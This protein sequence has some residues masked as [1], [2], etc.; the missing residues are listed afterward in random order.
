MFGAWAAHSVSIRGSVPLVTRRSRRCVRGVLQHRPLPSGRVPS[1]RPLRH[2]SSRL[3]SRISPVLWTRPTPRL[4]PDSFASSASYRGPGSL[5]R[6]RAR[7]GLPGSGALLSNVM[8]PSTPAGRQHLAFAVPH[9]LPSAMANA[10]APAVSVFRG[11]IPYP[12]RLLCTLRRGRR[13]PRRN[14]RYRAMR[15]HPT[16]AGL[17]PAG[18]HQLRLAHRHQTPPQMPPSPEALGMP[19]K[20]MD[21]QAIPPRFSMTN[22]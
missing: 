2:R 9:I 10:S 12:I 22:S 5:M 18:S 21:A 7:R 4:F 11:S 13:L 20:L 14:T 16:R 8:W 1:L 3:C 6:L 15:Y 17:A 19:I